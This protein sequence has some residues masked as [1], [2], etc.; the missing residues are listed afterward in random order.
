MNE[1]WVM[2]FCV[3]NF[4]NHTGSCARNS[5]TI[6]DTSL[7][8]NKGEMPFMVLCGFDLNVRWCTW[9]WLAEQSHILTNAIIIERKRI[10]KITNDEDKAEILNTCLPLSLL[11]NPTAIYHS[12]D[13]P[14]PP[15]PP[16]KKK[17]KKKDKK[18]RH[19][20]YTRGHWSHTWPSQEESD[21]PEGQ[22]SQWI[23][24]YLDQCSTK[25]SRL[26]PTTNSPGRFKAQ[27]WRDANLTTPVQMIQNCDF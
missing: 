15:P 21:T 7:R 12:L 27:D 3:T 25:M 20:T 18:K 19:R 17:K 24:W 22:Q 1:C 14:P 26:R 2:T 23:R 16:Q 9:S 4:I 13:T 10:S 5:R 11:S 6:Q 8:D